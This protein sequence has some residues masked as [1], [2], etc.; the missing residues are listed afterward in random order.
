MWSRI[1]QHLDVG[2]G[3]TTDCWEQVNA[4]GAVDEILHH[5]NMMSTYVV[6]TAWS[7]KKLLDARS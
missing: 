5:G 1:V 7:W 2:R 3:Q 4:V 6:I